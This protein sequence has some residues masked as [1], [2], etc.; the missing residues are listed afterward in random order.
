VLSFKAAFS[1]SGWKEYLA[2]GLPSAVMLF[3]EWGSYEALSLVAGLIDTHTLAAHTIM[4]TTVS[5]AFMP[6][7]GFAVAGSIRVG[8]KMGERKVED[9]KRVL[10]VLGAIAFAYEAMYVLCGYVAFDGMQCVLSSIM[11][12][13]GK[14]TI[15]AFANVGAY[16]VVG[17]PVA[18]AL[19]IP[20]EVGLAGIWWGFTLAVFVASIVL[21]IAV[22][23]VNWT[24]AS[25]VAVKRASQVSTH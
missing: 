16:V 18:Y 3:V 2:L 23:R 4:A 21:S 11:R 24:K 22:K 20:A 13:L 19:A 8:M 17:L 14:P 6:I 15:A 1:V 7:L 25:D 12:G 10:R 9:A 5:L